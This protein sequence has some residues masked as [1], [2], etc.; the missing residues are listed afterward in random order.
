MHIFFDVDGVLNTK[1][2]WK[3]IGTLNYKCVLSFCN[4]LNNV[5]NV[6]LVLTSSW[7]TGYESNK[8]KCSK[9]VQNLIE[10]LE[11]NGL[12]I[13]GATGYAPDHDRL[14]EI[15]HYRRKHNIYDDDY[16]VIDDDET[17]YLSF[18]KMNK[19]TMKRFLFVNAAV[20]FT[21]QDGNKLKRSIN[22]YR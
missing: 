14:K 19:D 12:K 16:F 4:A 6:H 21:N 2:D 8:Q 5:N 20:G 3:R 11:A 9:Q 18:S 22:R 1:E 15:D 7:R 10:A 17:E 13:E